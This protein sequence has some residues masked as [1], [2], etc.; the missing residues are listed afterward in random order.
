MNQSFIHLKK[1]ESEQIISEQI[2]SEQSNVEQSNVYE[3][4]GEEF[5]K[6]IEVMEV[7][8]EFLFERNEEAEFM[9]YMKEIVLILFQS[10]A[11]YDVDFQQYFQNY[12]DERDERR[13]KLTGLCNE[14]KTAI[15]EYNSQLEQRI[16]SQI[17]KI[18]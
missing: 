15:D 5:D 6:I 1:M 14:F 16:K 2:I 18:S 4:V 11:K 9:S 3:Y 10:I 13:Q 17:Q 12:L 7:Y 8:S